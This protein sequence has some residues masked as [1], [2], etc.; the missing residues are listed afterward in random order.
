MKPAFRAL[1]TLLFATLASS[2]C[3][4]GFRA[5]SNTELAVD[6][7]QTGVAYEAD[8]QIYR[9]QHYDL[10]AMWYTHHRSQNNEVIKYLKGIFTDNGQQ[11]IG[12]PVHISITKPAP[13]GEEV[14]VEKDDF[15]FDFFAVGGKDD[16]IYSAVTSFPLKPGKY[17][18]RITNLKAHRHLKFV[19]AKIKLLR[20]YR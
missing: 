19:P 11:R 20:M 15:I 7:S 2:G 3:A 8:F 16:P 14:I 5:Y 18:L 12:V 1:L 17:R 4:W 6:F 10:V 13:G 9:E